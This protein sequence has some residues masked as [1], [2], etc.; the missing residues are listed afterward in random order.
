MKKL[1][2]T[3]VAPSNIAF[4]KYWG[5]KDEILRLPENGSVSVS[6][7]NLLTK[8]TVEFSSEY[9]TDKII[10][11]KAEDKKEARR[12]INHLD[13]IRDLAH[14]N[15]KSKVVSSNNFPASS[16]LASSASGFAALTLAATKATGLSLTEKELSVLA[17][18]GS[19]SACRSIPNGIVEW[20]EGKDS[21]TSYAFS[22]FPPHHWA[23]GIIVAIVKGEKKE[24]GSTD[25][26][27]LVNTSPFF[28]ERLLN[29]EWKIKKIKQ[30]IKEKNFPLFGELLEAEALELHAITLTTRP[31]IIY[32]QPGTIK[33]MKL[34]QKARSEGLLGYFT[35]D[36]GPHVYIICEKK[37]VSGLV[38]RLRGIEEVRNIIV[39]EPGEGAR[40]VEE[41]LF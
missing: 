4:I 30:L 39:N 14:I 5:K 20:K 12:V 25:G 36:A 2:A 28:K 17:R 41:H 11:N 15:E 37:N 21:D 13:R 16:G 27:K 6:L 34:V 22:I 40:I 35:I 31:A 19:G 8:T 23:I 3:A 24:V 33:V 32:W 1:K 9:Q 18:I 29:I 10:I 26:M 38:K 7:S